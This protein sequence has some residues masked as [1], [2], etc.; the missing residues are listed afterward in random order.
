MKDSQVLFATYGD[1]ASSNVKE[2]QRLLGRMGLYA[3]GITG[4]FSD[5][6]YRAY[7]RA[8]GMLQRTVNRDVKGRMIVMLADYLA[9][10][11]WV[12][13]RTGAKTVRKAE[14]E[15]DGYTKRPAPP[16]DDGY[17]KRPVPP[18]DDGYTKRPVIAQEPIH[19]AA[20]PEAQPA[21]RRRWWLPLLLVVFL[22]AAASAA[23]W[24]SGVL[25]K[26]KQENTTMPAKRGVPS[27]LSE[28]AEAFV[29]ITPVPDAAVAECAHSRTTETVV[30]TQYR[31]DN[32]SR[33]SCTET[34][35]EK[36]VYCG[37]ATKRYTRYSYEAHTYSTG[38]RSCVRCGYAKPTS[39]PRATATNTP[40]SVF[41]TNI[42]GGKAKEL[43]VIVTLPVYSGPGTGYYRGADDKAEC[44]LHREFFLWGYE[45]GWYMISYATNAG[46]S[47]VGYVDGSKVDE[48]ISVPTLRF[49]YKAA[50]TTRSV[51]LTDD[52]DGK[53]VGIATLGS[54]ASVT[55]LATY[56]NW[57]YIECR[58]GGKNMRGFIPAG[59]LKAD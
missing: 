39:T 27:S 36:C 49:A 31:Q 32:S 47:R 19:A 54:G 50:R 9:L 34:V 16:E 28:A 10:E 37:T 4:N 1:R 48:A 15:D 20:V 46:A 5:S 41:T 25:G 30:G 24:Q 40:K 12:E 11:R 3:G 52:P 59:T 43:S 29:A 42:Y 22:M 51:S 8:C 56:G 18:E 57:Y 33:H 44:S 21:R 14:P 53:Q 55:Y 7:Q 23:L 26:E 2:L 45:K 38:G 13:G 58:I 17:T 6:T 35:E